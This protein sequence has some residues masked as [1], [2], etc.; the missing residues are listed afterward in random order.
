MTRKL[1][2]GTAAVVMAGIVATIYLSGGWRER[3]EVSGIV[4]MVLTSFPL[5]LFLVAA[6]LC[7]GSKSAALVAGMTVFAVLFGAAS[8]YSAF[9]RGHPDEV[10]AIVLLFCPL[11]QTLAAVAAFIARYFADKS[12]ATVST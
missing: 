2:L 7:K 9:W 5:L 12:Y 6:A 8:Y 11:L 4:V 10:S 1:K 3:H